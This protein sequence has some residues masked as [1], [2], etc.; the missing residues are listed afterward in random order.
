MGTP[1][2]IVDTLANLSRIG[3]DGVT[4]SWVNFQEELPRWIREVMPLLEQAGLRRPF[5]ARR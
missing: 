1:E 3:V 2:Q 5:T 4:L